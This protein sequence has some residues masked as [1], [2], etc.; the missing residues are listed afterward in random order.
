[1]VPT[2]NYQQLNEHIDITDSPF[3]INTELK[4]WETENDQPRRAAISSFGFSGTNAHLVIEEYTQESRL[5]MGQYQ[6]DAPAIILLSAKD[7]E[8]LK[9]HAINLNAYL[10]ANETANLYDVAYTLQVGR[11]AMEERL[12]FIAGSTEDLTN[13]LQNFSRRKKRG[14]INREY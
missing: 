6:S 4:D 10:K 3:Y 7:T 1:M 2:I 9:E 5:T 8:R 11:E 14:L 12:A 13:Q